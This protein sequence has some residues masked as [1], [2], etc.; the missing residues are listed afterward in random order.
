MAVFIWDEFEVLVT[1][2]SIFRA[3]KYEGWSK[4]VSKQK[5]R[6]RNVNFRDAYV[7]FILDFSSYHLVYVD[8]SGCNKQIGFRVA[9][10]FL[11]STNFNM[12]SI[13]VETSPI[14]F[15][16]GLTN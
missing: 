15:E 3:L 10:R 1:T 6:E 2:W 14:L 7:Q 12:T 16:V 4:K 8:E 13:I 11:K 9:P 5:A